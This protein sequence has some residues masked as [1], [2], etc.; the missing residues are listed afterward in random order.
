MRSFAKLRTATQDER[1]L[2]IAAGCVLPLARIVDEIDDR[3]QRVT[4]TSS[5][6][7][8]LVCCSSER[9]YFAAK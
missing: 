9:R 4:M 7:S 3:A 6:V 2:E 5:L 8:T 1:N